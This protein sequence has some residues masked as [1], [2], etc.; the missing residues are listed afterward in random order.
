MSIICG[1][2]LNIP[3]LDKYEPKTLNNDQIKALCILYYWPEEKISYKQK[4]SSWL[5]QFG[6]KLIVNKLKDCYD[7]VGTLVFSVN[8]S[9]PKGRAILK[10][11]HSGCGSP[12]I[13]TFMG[14]G[15]KVSKGYLINYKE[16]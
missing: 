5:N 7:N 16:E 13:I 15:S 12:G 8:G 14:C 11:N 3:V 10:V 9:P 4:G 1:G 2:Y 6:R